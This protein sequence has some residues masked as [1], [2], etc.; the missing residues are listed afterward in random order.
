FELEADERL[1]PDDPRVVAGLDDVGLA[2]RDL[3]LGAV[4]MRDVHRAGLGEAH[5][6]YLAALGA[7]D[8]LDALRPR[9][10]GLEGHSGRPG[11]APPPAGTVRLL[12]RPRP[13]RCAEI[14]ALT[15]SH[16][17]PPS[18]ATTDL[19]RGIVTSLLQIN[20]VALSPRPPPAALRN[21]DSNLPA[22]ERPAM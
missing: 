3:V 22:S 1:V 5:M 17:Q 18:L 2:R 12:R 13:R 21:E 16:S 4:V 14:P 11:A 7:D 6:P 20:E 8:R 10:A 15:P 9:P 19:R